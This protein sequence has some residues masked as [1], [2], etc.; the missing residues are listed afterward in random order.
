MLLKAG[1]HLDKQ[2][3]K[4]HSRSWTEKKLNN[5]KILKVITLSNLIKASL[6]LSPTQNSQFIKQ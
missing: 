3:K 5:P 1:F 4:I 6:R 2:Q